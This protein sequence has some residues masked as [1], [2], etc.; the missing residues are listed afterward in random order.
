[1]AIAA[2]LKG[3]LGA[4]SLLLGAILGIVWQPRRAFAA[5]V[6]A[7]G[8]GTLLAAIA[9]DI[10]RAVY[11]EGGFLPLLVGFFVGGALFTLVTRYI[12]ARG[13]FLRH[14]SSSRRYLY[15]QR[16]AATSSILDRL[17]HIEIMQHMAPAE[18]QA[19]APLLKPHFAE[20]GDV[21]CEEGQPGDS[22]YLILE[23]KAEIFKGRELITSLGAGEVFGEMALLT[24]EP[25][26]A[27]V[28]ASTPMALYELKRND[29]DAVVNRCPSLAG[30]LNRVLARRLQATTK[31]QAEARQRYNNWRRAVLDSTELHPPAPEQQQMMQQLVQRSAPL[32][33]LC[34]S[35][36]DNIPESAVIGMTAAGGH[37]GSSFLLAVFISNFPE[38]LSSS[39]GMK[40][41]GTRS[42]H[43]LSLWIGV[44]LLSGLS[45]VIGSLFQ[46][47]APSLVMA[48][49]Q[50]IAGGAILAMLASTMMPE[51]YELGGGSVNFSTISGFLLGFWVS[52]P[53]S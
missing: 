26:S 17:S 40:Q 47:T 1:M 9:F 19:I 23:G 43:I 22:L 5:A 30:A 2:L 38:A 53:H 8:S 6:M 34:G 3:M 16:Q 44:V 13:G 36:I 7:F 31:S 12:D 42:R 37:V 4:S 10:S 50:A 28:I 21:L 32:A 14:P 15:R 24:Q 11:Q 27:T 33:I 18:M 48:L 45:A 52:L 41:A 39:S 20:P 49:V 46:A 25:R 51:A 35:L 29:F